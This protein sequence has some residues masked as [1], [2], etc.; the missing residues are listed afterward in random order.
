MKP[1]NHLS[2]LRR[3]A[4]A[5]LIAALG[6][7]ACGC[8]PAN[9]LSWFIAPRH[10][11]QTIKAEYPLK[12]ERLV[13][14]TYAGTEILFNDPTAPLEVSSDLVNEILRSLR[15]RVK[16]IVHPVQV[17]RWQESNLEWPNMSLVDIAKA[18]QA[19]TIL[20][21]ELERYTM[22]EDRSANLYRGRVRARIQVAE[23]QAER[24][25]VYE[26]SVETVY[27]PE[28]P[29]GVLGTTERVIRHYTNAAFAVAVINKFHEYQVEV[30]GGRP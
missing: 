14:V 5:G 13:I 25:P 30:K 1:G 15:P 27:P 20:Y 28:G 18:F 2:P 21:V 8:P 3:Q 29:V 22:M 12:A 26:S 19:D 4:L 7:A 17:V 9:L 16:T 10:P 24:N 23:T 6:L 11:K